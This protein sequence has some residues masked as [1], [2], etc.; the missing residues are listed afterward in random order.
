MNLARIT[1]V[2]ALALAA[3]AFAGVLQPAGA[4]S[5]TEP[6]SGSI[7]VLGAGSA[8]VTPNRATFAFS[9]IRRITA[10]AEAGSGPQ[11]LPAGAMRDA[12]AQI[13]PGTQQIEATVSVTFALG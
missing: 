8:D 11:P 13:D 9:T 10:I 5:A 2:A 4:S 7:T 3:V 6:A 1:V 12:V